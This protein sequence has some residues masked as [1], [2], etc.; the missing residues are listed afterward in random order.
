MK[1]LGPHRAGTY[2]D[3]VTRIAIAVLVLGTVGCG[4]RPCALGGGDRISQLIDQLEGRCCG[5]HTEPVEGHIDNL[6]KPFDSSATGFRLMARRYTC[7]KWAADC[8]AEM[9]DGAE[10]AVPALI[11]AV[12]HGPNNYDTGDG[13]IPARDAVLRALGK[14]RDARG[15]APLLHAL[16]NPRPLSS[17]PGAAGTTPGGPAD[18]AAAA[19]AL[20]AIGPAAAGAVPALA[21]ILARPVAEPGDEHRLRAVAIALARIGDPSVVSPLTEALADPAKSIAAAEAL[22]EMGARA[23]AAGPALVAAVGSAPDRPGNFTIRHAVREVM[24]EESY[25]SLP[26]NWDLTLSEMSRWLD[27]EA[28]ITGCRRLNLHNDGPNESLAETLGGG[29]VLVT[30]FPRA[31]W[32]ESRRVA[33]TF[34]IERDGQVVDDRSFASMDDWRRLARAALATACPKGD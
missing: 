32:V 27:H 30:H 16:T 9:G 26:P 11:A 25:R 5:F 12:E 6:C 20:G 28:K 21:A 13:V 14:T 7:A 10:S 29:Y 19:E 23:A 24:G 8:L 3:G 4:V 18:E 1:S 15:V 34:R 31:R 17:G 2:I 22:G 33:G